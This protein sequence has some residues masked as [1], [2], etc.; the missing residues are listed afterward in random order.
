MSEKKTAREEKLA[1]LLFS[2][3]GRDKM[4]KKKIAREIICRLKG[5]YLVHD[6]CMADSLP[7]AYYNEC[8][9]AL[10]SLRKLIDEGRGEKKK[11]YDVFSDR[12]L[13]RRRGF[14]QSHDQTTKALDEAGIK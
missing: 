10:H 4:S 7:C 5:G 6:N 12:T 3:I 14:N 1:R 8:T 11:L 9:N 2:P 13:L